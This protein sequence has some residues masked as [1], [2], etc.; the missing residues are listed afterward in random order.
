MRD[1][2]V[3]MPTIRDGPQSMGAYL[4][5]MKEHRVDTSRLFFLFL[6]EDFVEKGPMLQVLKDHGVEGAVLGQKERDA[7][8]AERHLSQYAH[9]VPKRSHAETSFGLLWMQADRSFK[10]GIFLDDDTYPVAGHDLVGEH[11]RNL[12]HKG[13]ILTLSSSSRWVNV[14]HHSP[15]T[16]RMYPRGYPYGSMDETITTRRA[17]P[18]KVVA[19]QGLWTA[20]PD[21][22]A[23]RITSLGGVEGV[24]PVS[25]E[26]SDF[27]ETFN[28]EKGNQLTVC[29]MNLAFRREVIPAFWQMPMDDNPWKVGRFDDIW[30]GVVLKHI[31]D[32]RNAA[33]LTGAPLC[34]HRKAKRSVFKDLFA[35]AAG[36]EINEHLWRLIEDAPIQDKD[37]GLAYDAVA[38]HLAK[39]DVA[40]M[41]NGAFVPWMAERMSQWVDVC[42]RL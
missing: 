14:L 12:E 25:L 19:S 26:T 33:I 7:W 18:G 17:A 11:M 30:S 13:P 39:K 2:C 9:L 37:W 5:S 27:G 4:A 1:T 29:S 6:T 15:R 34:E 3:I 24:P 35:E 41:L 10:T 31:A 32:A 16:R 22:D 20:V 21:L 42:G 36:L 40:R 8:F 28:V 38:Q 23:A